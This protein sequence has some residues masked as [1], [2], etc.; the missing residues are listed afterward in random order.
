MEPTDTLDTTPPLDDRIIRLTGEIS[1]ESAEN[2]IVDLHN[3]AASPG[4]ISVIITSDGG[5]IEDGLRIIDALNIIKN[6]GRTIKTIVAKAYSMAAFIAC[7]GTIRTIY[8]HGRLMFHAGRYYNFESDELTI[9]NI[10]ALYTELSHFNDTLYDI[11][12][13]VC[14]NNDLLNKLTTEDVY[15]NAQNAIQSGIIHQIE[16]N[17]I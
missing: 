2:F 17:I 11:I 9:K 6:Q 16:T 15:L 13:Q 1:E 7:C 5:S 14:T 12:R 10:N 8:P 4:D 3:L